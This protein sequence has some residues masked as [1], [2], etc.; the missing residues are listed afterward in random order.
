MSLYIIILLHFVDLPLSNSFSFCVSLV[1]YVGTDISLFLEWAGHNINQGLTKGYEHSTVTG[2][3]VTDIRQLILFTSVCCDCT[4]DMLVF[5]SLA[6][7]GII[8]GTL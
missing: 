6:R 1:Q 4:E 5:I 3:E 8:K 2:F 7:W